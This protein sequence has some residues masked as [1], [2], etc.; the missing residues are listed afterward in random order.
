MNDPSGL[1]WAALCICGQ[2]WVPEVAL[3]I[4]ATSLIYLEV[5]WFR[6]V[7]VRKLGS[8]MYGFHQTI[9][10]FSYGVGKDP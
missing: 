8:F 6:V 1:V 2:L 5:G 3:M 7:M 10:S 4:L 9:L